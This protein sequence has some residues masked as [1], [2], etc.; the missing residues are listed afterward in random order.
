MADERELSISRI[1]DAPREKIFEA[2]TD[3]GKLSQWW[4]PRP[5]AT[6]FCEI[7]PRSGG[8][9]KTS[10]VGPDGVEYPANGVYL[11]VVAPSKIVFTDA[12]TES[13]VPAEK[14]FMTVTITFED[15]DGKTRYTARVLHWTVEDRKQHEEMGFHEG[16][17]Q[18]LDQLTAL[19]TGG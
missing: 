11:E 16:W 12:Y 1:I 7:D 3:P 4:A 15:V 5:Y 9:F 18:C 13:W 14:P 17:G 19:V 10:M 8:T 6:P 2:W